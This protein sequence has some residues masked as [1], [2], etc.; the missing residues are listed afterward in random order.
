M[1]DKERNNYRDSPNEDQACLQGSL[2]IKHPLPAPIK[3]VFSYSLSL[4]GECM[5]API[6]VPSSTRLLRML[7][8]PGGP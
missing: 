4:P 5:C 1:T 8:H 7:C 2:R 3:K 6:I